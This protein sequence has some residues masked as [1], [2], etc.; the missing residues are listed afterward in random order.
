ML[1]SALHSGYT[2]QK[3]LR[4]WN[5]P[6]QRDWVC[7]LPNFWV[8]TWQKSSRE[9]LQNFTSFIYSYVI[10][11][12]YVNI[13]KWK[14]HFYWVFHWAQ[15]QKLGGVDCYRGSIQ[16]NLLFCRNGPNFLITSQRQEFHGYFMFQRT[17]EAT[18]N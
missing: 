14:N 7:T 13:Y 5:D 1:C 8:C 12:S 6:G 4:T 9:M 18:T 17:S 10:Y 11:E 16:R 2:P 3:F 15:I